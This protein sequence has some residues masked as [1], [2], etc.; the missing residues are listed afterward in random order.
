M[1]INAYNEHHEI[2]GKMQLIRSDFLR[3][4]APEKA[5]RSRRSQDITAKT[6]SFVLSRSKTLQEQFLDYSFW[7]PTWFYKIDC[8]LTD[9]K[10]RAIK[11][12]E[13][14]ELPEVQIQI[15]G[16]HTFSGR[17]ELKLY[18]DGSKMRETMGSACIFL[19]EG[20]ENHEIKFR[21]SQTNPS[22]NKAELFAILH[23]L[24]NHRLTTCIYL[25]QRPWG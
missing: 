19:E 5:R 8:G 6:K 10:Y 16:Q 20:K 2:L 25:G 23:G 18:T 22:R 13:S 7:A 11:E 3:P 15:Q 24:E 1:T 14:L 9:T 17:K 21:P 12:D 4:P